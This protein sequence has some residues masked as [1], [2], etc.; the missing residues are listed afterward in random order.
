MMLAVRQ[1]IHH[2]Q[3]WALRYQISSK[4]FYVDHAIKSRRI[5]SVVILE[6]PVKVVVN[7]AHQVFRSTFGKRFVSHTQQ[8]L[9]RSLAG[10][11]PRVSLGRSLVIAS[12]EP[13]RHARYRAS[14]C[15]QSPM[16]RLRCSLA[17]LTE[18]GPRRGRWCVFP[19]P[20]L[21]RTSGGILGLADRQ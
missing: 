6:R 10:S 11:I 17:R 5:N 3:F 19:A 15:S 1:I 18:S 13:R 16:M 2:P 4:N 9:A 12:L 20:Y 8:G 21:Y 7:R 14:L